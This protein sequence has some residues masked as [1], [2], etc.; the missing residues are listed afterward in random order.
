MQMDINQR[1]VTSCI[2]VHFRLL[3]FLKTYTNGR[4]GAK[5][6][7]RLTNS[8]ELV[9]CNNMKH[10]T[11]VLIIIMSCI[12]ITNGNSQTSLKTN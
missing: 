9:I 1:L 5:F 8:G 3:D 7:K 10:K 2:P 6:S 4:K 11:V 12:L